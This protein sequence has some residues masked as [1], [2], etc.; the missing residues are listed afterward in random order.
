M[1]KEEISNREG[2]EMRQIKKEWRTVAPFSYE[3]R[4]SAVTWHLLFSEDDVVYGEPLILARNYWSHSFQKRTDANK[5][6]RIV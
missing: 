6:E 5:K 1:G 4:G 2:Q 3:V